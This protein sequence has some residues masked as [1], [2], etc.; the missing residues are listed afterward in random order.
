MPTDYAY[1]ET[2]IHLARAGSK[3]AQSCLLVLYRPLMCR[4]AAQG[5]ADER[6]DVMQDLGVA[7]LKAL[8]TFEPGKGNFTAYLEGCFHRVMLSRWQDKSVKADVSLDYPATE[9]TDS[10]LSELVPDGKGSSE[11]QYLKQTAQQAARRRLT[12]W[13]KTLTDKQKMV[14]RLHCLKGKSL[15]QIAREQGCAYSVVQKHYALAVK[16]LKEDE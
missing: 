13:P 4:F 7:L 12:R 1:M 10:P 6:E 2:Q 8:M 11:K 15:R 5:P 16:K 3:A 9:E 14:V